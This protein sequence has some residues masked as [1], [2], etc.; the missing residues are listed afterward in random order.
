MQPWRRGM[1][2]SGR[3]NPLEIKA[4]GSRMMSPG[5]RM[6][7]IAR[8]FDWRNVVLAPRWHSP[9]PCCAHGWL[10]TPNLNAVK[11]EIGL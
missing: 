1:H 7:S 4:P 9:S 3:T 8:C 6:M 5:S 11:S 2:W 10:Q